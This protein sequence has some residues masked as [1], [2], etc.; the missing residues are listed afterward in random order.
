[1]TNPADPDEIARALLAYLRDSLPAPDISFAEKPAPIHGGNRSFV[2]GFR[3]S[4]APARHAGPLILRVLR[5]PAEGEIAH[6]EAAV[7]SALVD[8]GYPAPRIVAWSTSSDALG[9]AFQVMERIA[10]RPL[11]LADP[12]DEM[13]GGSLLRQMLPDLGRLLFGGWPAIFAAAQVH[14]HG[15]DSGRFVAALESEGVPRDRLGLPA[16][17]DRLKAA[18]DEYSLAGLRSGVQ[19]LRDNQPAGGRPL[20]ICH[21][22]FFPL[23]VYERQGKVTG[24]IDWSDVL[25]APAEHDVGVVKAGIETLPAMLGPIGL[26]SQRWVAHRYVAAYRQL[27]PLDPASLRYAEA[28]RCFR[29]LLGVAERRLAISGAIPLEPL[30]IPYDD[31]T[32]ERRLVSRFRDITAVILRIPAA[33]QP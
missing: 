18:V 19:W 3:L 15:L 5:P 12:P 29:T 30:P 8:L 28:H 33:Q 25:L 11:V 27:R 16:G 10:G 14:L 2:Y 1:V 21:G 24:V 26:L 32:S 17:L 9:G 23:H 22:D 6:L 7:Q 13:T 31:P 4:G 20:S